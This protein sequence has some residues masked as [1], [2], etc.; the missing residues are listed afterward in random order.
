M[1]DIFRGH[2]KNLVFFNWMN[3]PINAGK[4]TRAL[5]SNP[6]REKIPIFPYAKL[7]L[8][9]LGVRASP[10]KSKAAWKR[11]V[12]P[13]LLRAAEQAWRDELDMTESLW[14]YRRYKLRLAPPFYTTMKGFRG[15]AA[16]ARARISSLT[17]RNFVTG[18]QCKK[19]GTT[20]DPWFF[21]SAGRKVFQTHHFV[22]GCPAIQE[23]L[24][25][26]LDDAIW[27]PEDW[28]ARRWDEKLALLLMIKDGDEEVKDQRAVRLTGNYLADICED[29]SAS[30][31][32][33]RRGH[34]T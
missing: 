6:D 19:C 25:S 20:L 2:Y 32:R 33:P 8:N 18:R 30:D 16:L 29:S 24:Q 10:G 15:R 27:L 7:L 1:M 31:P 12:S 23:R 13:R 28:D 4:W 14:L 11:I 21:H 26:L 34:R 3:N 22:L 5:T 17:M 9:E